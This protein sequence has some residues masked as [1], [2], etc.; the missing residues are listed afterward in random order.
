MVNRRTFITTGFAGL[1]SLAGLTLSAT[2]AQAQTHRQL[3]L[4]LIFVGAG[5]CSQC[6]LAAPLVQMVAAQ[7]NLPVL[8]ASQDGQ[9]IPPFE[10]V[11]P[12]QGHPIADQIR[13]FPALLFYAPHEDA[14]VARLDGISHPKRYIARL[15]ATLGDLRERGHVK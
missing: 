9:A 2:G 14:I 1:T 5:W 12:S 8:V 4:G 13:A 10:Q 7:E 11:Q 15:A 3:D 6:H